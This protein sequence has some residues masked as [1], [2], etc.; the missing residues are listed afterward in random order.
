MVEQAA[1]IAPLL[2]GDI[3]CRCS[4]CKLYS[5][6]DMTSIVRRI[7]W[8][9]TLALHMPQWITQLLAPKLA[10]IAALYTEARTE[11]QTYLDQK[12]FDADTRNVYEQLRA[13]SLPESDKSPKRCAD[14]VVTLVLAGS[15][16]T[17]SMVSFTIFHVLNDAKIL[18]KLREELAEVY[19]HAAARPS[20]AKLQ[21]LSYL[22][23]QN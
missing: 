9:V 3:D 6:A 13:S 2:S 19:P 23:S 7:P 21:N 16:T 12:T 22:V 10:R 8:I 11:A 15:E 20:L 5:L 18:V 4:Q 17:A 1:D 14:E